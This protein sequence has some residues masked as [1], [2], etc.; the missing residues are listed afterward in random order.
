M[1]KGSEN[2]KGECREFMELLRKDYKE[3]EVVSS[4]ALSER[5][6]NFCKKNNIRIIEG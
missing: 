2:R 4:I 3:K 1:E 6:S 5:W